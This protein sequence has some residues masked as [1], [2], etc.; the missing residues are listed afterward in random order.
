[1][2]RDRY[3]G[4]GFRRVG[5]AAG[6]GVPI[7]DAADERRDEEH[8]RIRAGRRLRKREQQGQAMAFSVQA[9]PNRNGIPPSA[10][11]ALSVNAA[12]R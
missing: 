5:A 2:L 9:D 4:V 7:Q 1:M 11:T 12:V 8:A 3:A 10:T 6:L